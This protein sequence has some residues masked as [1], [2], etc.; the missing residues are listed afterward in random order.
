MGEQFEAGNNLDIPN[1]QFSEDDGDK[2]VDEPGPGS[3]WLTAEDE[4]DHP[5]NRTARDRRCAWA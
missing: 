1:L 5:G 2:E 4:E 3:G